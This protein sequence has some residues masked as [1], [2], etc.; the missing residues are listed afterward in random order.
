MRTDCI[1]G[2]LFAIGD[3]GGYVGL[4]LGGSAVSVFEILDFVVYNSFLKLFRRQRKFTNSKGP[5]PEVSATDIVDAKTI[6]D[7]HLSYACAF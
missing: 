5:D 1:Y 3:L 4:F 6:P 2:I 7:F